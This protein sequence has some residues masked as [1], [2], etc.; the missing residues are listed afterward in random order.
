[1]IKVT[2]IMLQDTSKTASSKMLYNASSWSWVSDQ[3]GNCYFGNQ[4]VYHFSLE[5]VTLL[6]LEVFFYIYTQ[7]L[8]L[9]YKPVTRFNWNHQMCFYVFLVQLWWSNLRFMSV[10]FPAKI[11]GA[12]VSF[13]FFTRNDR[14]TPIRNESAARI[15]FFFFKKNAAVRDL[16]LTH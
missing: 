1:M 2:W 6:S 12:S 9:H 15:F 11:S 4:K 7:H 13:H 10:N 14:I 16:I 3:Q 5:N 8:G